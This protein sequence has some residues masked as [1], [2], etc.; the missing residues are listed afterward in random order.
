MIT[1]LRHWIFPMAMKQALKVLSWE[2]KETTLTAIS[3]VSMGF[4][5]W[6][7]FRPLMLTMPGIPLLCWWRFF[8]KQRKRWL[9]T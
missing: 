1:T 4:T 8:L 9:C 3:S 6:C 5:D 7:D 2:L